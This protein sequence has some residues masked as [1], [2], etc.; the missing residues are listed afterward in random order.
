MAVT[1]GIGAMKAKMP[2]TGPKV[3]LTILLSS[4][5]VER[6]KDVV[7][8]TPGLTLSDMAE[9]AFTAAIQEREKGRKKQFPP[10]RGK[11]KAGRPIK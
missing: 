10:R 8:W 6:V 5:L 11:L 2:P 9:E 7:Y 1:K 4:S 3:R